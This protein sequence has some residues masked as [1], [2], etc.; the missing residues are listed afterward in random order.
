MSKYFWIVQNVELGW[1]NVV[2]II[3]VED[4]EIEDLI[5]EFQGD[6]YVFQTKKINNLDYY[7]G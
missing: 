7:R 2:A 1:D 6:T 4:C 3:P 5:E